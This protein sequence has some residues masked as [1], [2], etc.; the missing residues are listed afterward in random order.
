MG[1]D[2][3]IA[4]FDTKKFSEW[5]RERDAKRYESILDEAPEFEFRNMFERDL[6][7][8]RDLITLV[9]DLDRLQKEKELDIDSIYYI[10]SG[11]PIHSS[12]SFNSFW[13]GKGIVIEM[14]KIPEFLEKH[15]ERAA[16]LW[17]KLVGNWNKKDGKVVDTPQN[18]KID[19]KNYQIDKTD[20]GG[21]LQGEEIKEL[22]EELRPILQHTD[23]FYQGL[24]ERYRR[25]AEMNRPVER[26]Y[27]LAEMMGPPYNDTMTMM[28]H[29]Y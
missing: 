29:F 4:I 13:C 21:F 5:C 7:A 24:D 27:G 11:Y 3:H 9:E 8:V 16:R 19:G 18:F 10:L 12:G 17:N 23:G 26:F 14:A 28:Y 22:A 25:S 6:D 1:M 2:S 15:S 20:A